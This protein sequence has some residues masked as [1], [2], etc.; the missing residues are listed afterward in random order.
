MQELDKAF[1]KYMRLANDQKS[2]GTGLGLYITKIIIDT[3]GG[4]IFIDSELEKGTK[5]SFYLPVSN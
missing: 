2:V 4:E 3:H 5:I 1:E